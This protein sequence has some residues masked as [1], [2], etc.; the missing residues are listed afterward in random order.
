MKLNHWIWLPVF[1]ALLTSCSSSHIILAY[2]NP[3]IREHTYSKIV[4][5]G[6]LKNNNDSLR[7]RVEKMFADDLRK[8]G[9]NAVAASDE[10]ASENFAMT[11]QAETYRELCLKGVD[12][13][14]TVALVD[15]SREKIIRPS[16][17]YGYP[18]N[19]Y[20]E[21][22]WHYPE[23]LADLSAPAIRPTPHY[24]WECILFDLATLEA[25]CTVQ[26]KAF[27]WIDEKRISRDFENRVIGRM[28]KAH[29]LNPR[30]PASNP[31]AF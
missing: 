8:I 2:K 7:A 9:Y 17:V 14:I 22:V 13:V 6:I 5:V 31:K 16:R 10:F 1:V 11:S 20:Y 28:T 27:R 15:P 26:T 18:N 3:N 29:V 30:P 19:Y 12:A 4:V 23:I 24:F 25:Q 21:R